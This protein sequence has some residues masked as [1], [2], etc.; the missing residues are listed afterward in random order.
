MYVAHV[1]TALIIVSQ[2]TQ[3]GV[4]DGVCLC[5]RVYRPLGSSSLGSIAADDVATAAAAQHFH[6][7]RLAAAAAAMRY[8]P[9]HFSPHPC[10]PLP[11]LALFPTRSL[12]VVRYSTL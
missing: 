7:Q 2:L 4:Y 11:G 12:S 5:V 8:S 1:N 9:Y 10:L 3:Y 6:F